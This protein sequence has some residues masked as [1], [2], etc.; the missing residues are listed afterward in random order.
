MGS[1]GG[2]AWFI[3]PPD[4]SQIVAHALAS[5]AA[6]S[7]VLRRIENEGSR[8]WHDA[9]LKSHMWPHTLVDNDLT[10]DALGSPLIS[11][12]NGI[13][14]HVGD[15]VSSFLNAWMKEG[16]VLFHPGGRALVD[17]LAQICPHYAQSFELSKSVLDDV[18]NVGAA[19][20]CLVL[21]RALNAKMVHE[22]RLGLFA[23]GPGIVS[24]LLILDG[25]HA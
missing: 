3:K 5:D 14:K 25:W 6:S 24:T 15:E 23:L 16:S 2:C 17:T 8:S 18:G 11:V 22:N 12:G 21:E 4:V 20:L 13:R 10:V 7:M 9:S 19:S 1:Y